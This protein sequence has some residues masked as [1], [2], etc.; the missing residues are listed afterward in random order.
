MNKASGFEGRPGQN[1]ESSERLPEG[2][3][4]EFIESRHTVSNSG[5][6]GIILKFLE[7]ELPPEIQSA[8]AFDREENPEG[9]LSVKA[10]K[11]Y[12]RTD[13]DKE[14]GML[15]KAREIVAENDDPSAS[16][17]KVPKAHASYNLEISETFRKF[18]NDSGASLVDTSVGIVVMDYIEGA[19][20]ATLLYREALKR[21]YREGD[22]YIPDE[23]EHISF[24]ELHRI[25]GN[26]L[27]FATPGG[28]SRNEN[29][30]GFE[31]EKVKSENAEKL[32]AALEASGFV[33]PP[34]VLEQ[35]QNTI[36]EWHRN[37]FYHNDLHERQIILKDGDLE[38]PR[39]FI[40]DYG[41]ASK[42][43]PNAEP[44]KKVMDDEAIV[45]RLSRLTKTAGQK[46]K[47]RSDEKTSHWNERI[48][49]ISTPR[50]E[51]EYNALFKAV[52]S[53]DH[54]ALNTL[55]AASSSTDTDLNNFLAMLIRIARETPDRGGTITDFLS[56]HER[57]TK[58]R[59]FFV[60]QVREAK[61]VVAEE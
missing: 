60:R 33:L 43:R 5:H 40:I 1:S 10:L 44:G 45:R 57:D 39:A 22:A 49:M 51:T 13:A 32:F 36:R 35:V 16:L 37:N 17:A 48:T 55:L 56:I 8:I 46:E 3:V 2:A 6:N 24:N 12:N 53:G 47:E 15:R 42:R 30:R 25:L 19:D 59:P 4:R 23:L 54:E 58:K 14:F 18:L 29:E 7:Q 52:D 50:H 34:A 28:K 21:T 41:A 31:E 38:N 20:L 61:E 11:I 27:H 9:S 26:K